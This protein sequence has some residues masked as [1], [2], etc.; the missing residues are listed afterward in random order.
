MV[1]YSNKYEA[2]SVEFEYGKMKTGFIII[3]ATYLDRVFKSSARVKKKYN[4]SFFR[5]LVLKSAN[6]HSFV[7]ALT[8]YHMLTN[9]DLTEKITLDFFKMLKRRNI[10]KIITADLFA[11]KLLKEAKQKFQINDL[12][13]FEFSEMICNALGIKPVEQEI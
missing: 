13:I 12:E 3:T 6:Q 7:E 11:Y 2:L 1:D 10:K 8:V 9:K 5:E 4:I